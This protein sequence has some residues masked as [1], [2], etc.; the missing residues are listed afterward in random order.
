MLSLMRE[1]GVYRV[2]EEGYSSTS[3]RPCFALLSYGTLMDTA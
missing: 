3:T 1:E 2:I